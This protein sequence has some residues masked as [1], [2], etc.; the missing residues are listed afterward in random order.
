MR[1]QQ[2]VSA[3]SLTVVAFV[4]LLAASL[5]G[6]AYLPA[7]AVAEHVQA[8]SPV[9]SASPIRTRRLRAA[10]MTCRSDLQAARVSVRDK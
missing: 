7:D 3:F 2:L 9:Q 10:L 4:A 1:V 8:A 6:Q 5:V